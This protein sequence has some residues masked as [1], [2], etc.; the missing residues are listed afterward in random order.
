MIA[1]RRSHP[2]F[3]RRGWFQGRPLHGEGCG[4]LAWFRIDGSEMSDEDW[5]A[6][7]I[8][9]VGVFLNGDAITSTD[10]RGETIVDDTFMV[11]LNAHHEP[12]AFVLPPERFGAAWVK[13]VDT[14]DAF[15]EGDQ[16]KAAE[17]AQVGARS[18]TL[19]RR[20]A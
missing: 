14:T 19:L 4:D 17:T 1:L 15:A 8:N 12:L 5:A 7:S 6:G 13:L 9:A 2:V 18:L 3:R 11:L 10:E 16:L 20:T